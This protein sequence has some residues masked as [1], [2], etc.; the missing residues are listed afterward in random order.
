M[1]KNKISIPFLDLK[2]T[3]LPLKHEINKAIQNVIDSSAFILGS[4]VHKFEKNFSKYLKVKYCAGVSSGTSALQMALKACN[5]GIGDEV[6]T[7]SHSWVS[8]AESISN[9]GATPIFVDIDEN[10]YNID[11]N[12]IEKKISKKTKCILPVH[13][14]G[15]PADMNN[16]TRI[17][18]ANNLFVI[19]DAAQAHGAK[20]DNKYCGTFGDLACFSFFPS[21]NLGSFG[22]SGAVVG[23]NKKLI[24]N[25]KKLR[26]HGRISKNKF[27][28]L[29]HN[30]RMDG[31]Q[32]AVLNVKLKSLEK[33][34]KL[35]ID[36]AK[37]YSELLNGY[38]KIPDFSKKNRHSFHIYPILVK[39]RN[40]LLKRFNENKIDVRVHYPIPIHKQPLYNKNYRNYFLPNTDKISKQ[41]ISLPLF[42][43]IKK[44]EIELVSN[45]LKKYI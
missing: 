8:T 42:P 22:D 15:N 39:K 10:S 18:K 1:I 5:I 28:V 31:I 25:I 35:R 20:I 16:I 32:A 13:L 7:T 12:Q 44:R 38:C 2:R 26:D 14:Y 36:A 3:Y 40:L 4:E 21:K 37:Q 45:C 30:E 24:E 19:E 27:G 41:V 23:K 34:I 17:A 6:I 11:P 33:Y 29:G 43:G 9:V